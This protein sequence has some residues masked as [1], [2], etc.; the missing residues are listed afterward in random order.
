MEKAT[1]Y[2][3]KICAVIPAAGKGIRLGL[4][5]P[6]ILI[7]INANIKVIDILFKA[8]NEYVD[9]LI[10]IVA[11]DVISSVKE[12]INKKRYY[13]G[14]NI[15]LVV[16]KNPIGM[17]DAIFCSYDKW[18]HFGHIIIVWGDQLGISKNTI[19]KVIDMHVNSGQQ[20]FTLPGVFRKDPYVEYILQDGRL[21][22]VL[23][24]RENDKLNSVG[25]SDIGVFAISTLN[26]RA[27]WK[28]YLKINA[29]GKITKEINF[30]PFLAYLSRNLWA[31]N[32]IVV[33]NEIEAKG[34][35]DTED[36]NF[37]RGY[38]KETKYKDL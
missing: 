10:I 24:K 8:L 11:P 12:Y 3:K 26:I 2:M 38:Y 31:I 19:K 33:N 18:K 15:E 22:D 9:K 13:H 25:F 30:L 35:N 32:K 17:G 37:F 20:T 21:I 23:Q 4:N 14:A 6:K 36:L 27:N 16:Q 1:R 5:T 29:Y 28:K 34:L 7:D